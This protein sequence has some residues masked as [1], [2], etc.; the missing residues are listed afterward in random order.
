MANMD[1]EIFD[2]TTFRDLC[3]EVVTRSESK[4]NQLDVLI[5][6]VRTL[7]KNGNDALVFL[8]RI[9]EFLD[10]GVKNDEQIIKLVAVVQRLQS[11]QLE[12][13]G[14]ENGGLSEEEKEQLLINVAKEEIKEIKQQVDS[15]LPI[16]SS[17]T[18]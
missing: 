17:L 3:K 7:I 12:V 16:T 11:T 15:I 14:G 1:F 6:D 13:T 2:G 10:V 5:S 8:P 4:K 9:K 18:S